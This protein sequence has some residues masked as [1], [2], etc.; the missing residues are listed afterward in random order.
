MESAIL[1]KIL[2]MGSVVALLVYGYIQLKKD[3]STNQNDYK[4]FVKHVME[5]NKAR[6][7]SYKKRI[8]ELNDCLNV[9]AEIRN[10]VKEIKQT[11]LNIKEN[12]D[13]KGE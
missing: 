1:T 5:E 2:E 10:D 3:Y 11:I 9:V 8:D 7:I 12:V 6:E 4:E 13:K